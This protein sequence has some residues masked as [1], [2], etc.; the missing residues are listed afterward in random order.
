MVLLVHMPGA[1][2]GSISSQFLLF[3]DLALAGAAMMYAQQLSKD[4]SVIG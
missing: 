4:R 3:K 2:A 1:M